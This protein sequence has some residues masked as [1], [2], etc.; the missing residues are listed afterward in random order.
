MFRRR[1]SPCAVAYSLEF[2][3]KKFTPGS[4]TYEQIRQLQQMAAQCGA[5]FPAKSPKQR[6][7]E[8]K[9]SSAG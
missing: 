6:R 1:T 8:R 5:E 4:P 7:E 2:Q 3:L 9:A